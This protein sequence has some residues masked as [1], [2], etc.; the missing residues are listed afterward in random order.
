MSVNPSMPQEINNST[1]DKL[2]LVK[3]E[4]KSFTS[5]YGFSSILNTSNP[6]LKGLWVVFFLILFSSLIQNSLENLNDYYQYTVITKIEK[7]KYI[8]LKFENLI[9]SEKNY[10]TA[11][12]SN[13]LF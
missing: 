10:I 4:L 8:F 2:D 11:I 1:K 12:N 3:N 13:S 7:T 6:F 5:F 9:F